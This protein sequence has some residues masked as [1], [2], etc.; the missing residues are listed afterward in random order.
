MTLITR[1]PRA[2]TDDLFKFPASCSVGVMEFISEL[3]D[4][5]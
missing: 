4:L 3:A 5:C 2:A 1:P